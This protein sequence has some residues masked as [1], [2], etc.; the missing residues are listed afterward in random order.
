[1]SEDDKKK[2]K[3]DKL[4]LVE[5]ESLDNLIDLTAR[6]MLNFVQ[7][8]KF[9]DVHL[10]YLQYGGL[11]GFGTTIYFVRKKE[12]I[13]NKYIVYNK[14]EDKIIFTDKLD[15]RGNLIYIPIIHVKKQN[16]ISEEE[17]SKFLED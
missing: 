14:T 11:P 7:H 8:F 6:S 2:E 15:P 12:P 1:M 16:I 3:D 4:G 9:K 5:L 17:L 10:Y 13:T